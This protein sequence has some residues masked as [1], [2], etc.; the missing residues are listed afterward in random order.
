MLA[1]K[2]CYVSVSIL[3]SFLALLARVKTIILTC[4]NF[5]RY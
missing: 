1:V 3:L 4:H 5:L 2:L